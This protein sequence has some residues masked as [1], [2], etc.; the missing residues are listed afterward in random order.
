MSNDN[1]PDLVDPLK[2][3][4]SRGVLEGSLPL[5]R[6]ARAVGLLVSNE[7]DL[8]YKILFDID[9][10]DV[11]FLEG[12]VT[13]SVQLRCQRCMESLVHELQVSFK[14]SPV[15]R[16]SQ[17]SELPTEYEAIV[18]DEGKISPLR[19]IEDELILSLPLVP[20]HDEGDATCQVEVDTSQSENEEETLEKPFEV[21]KS[22]KIKV[23]RKE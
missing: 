2:L 3:S 23:K 19:L 1:I 16:E 11:P 9:H 22:L 17:G 15:H 14:L 13:G 8:Q 5:S 18:M 4:K 10:E 20:K 12:N 7:G 6:L 21:L